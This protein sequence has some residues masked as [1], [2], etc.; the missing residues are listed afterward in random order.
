MAKLLSRL[1]FFGFIAA[2]CER[3]DKNVETVACDPKV[4]KCA[5]KSSTSTDTS[6]STTS[7]DSSSSS[8]GENSTDTGDSGATTFGPTPTPTPTDNSTGGSAT[9][10]GSGGGSATGGGGS[11]GSSATGGGGSATGDGGSGGGSATGGGPTPSPSNETVATPTPIPLQTIDPTFQVAALGVTASLDASGN[12]KVLLPPSTIARFTEMAYSISVGTKAPEKVPALNSPSPEASGFLDA[13]PIVL[14]L[15]LSF[16]FDGKPCQSETNL[17]Q[18][19]VPANVE[20]RC[21]L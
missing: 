8:T 16:K 20:T 6:S 1:L 9:G 12:L 2:S 18:G 13:G 15:M 11:G 7:S 4:S 10:G 14:N 19:P 17:V 5:G 3:S 21:Q